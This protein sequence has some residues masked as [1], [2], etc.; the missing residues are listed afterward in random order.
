MFVDSN[1]KTLSAVIRYIQ[2]FGVET[3]FYSEIVVLFELYLVSPATNGVSEKSA[4]SVSHVK[5]MAEMYS[6]TRKIE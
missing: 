1:E 4:C 2:N 6:V 3:D 5:K